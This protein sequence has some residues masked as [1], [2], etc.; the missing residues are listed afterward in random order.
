MREHHE[1]LIDSSPEATMEATLR[2]PVAPDW[3]VRLLFLLR[4][5][6]AGQ[7]SILEFGSTDGF[8]LLEQTPT[9]L[10]FGAAGRWQGG[11]R[12][13][14]NCDEWLGWS[15]PGIKIVADFRALPTG[16]GRTRLTTETRVWPLDRASAFV[17]R[18]YWLVVGPFSALIRRRWLRAIARSAVAG[19]ARAPTG[20][21]DVQAFGQV[22]TRGNLA[23]LFVEGTI[24]TSDDRPV[25]IDLSL[26]KIANLPDPGPGQKAVSASARGTVILD[27][28][29][30]TG[31]QPSTSGEI[32]RSTN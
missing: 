31:G 12:S 29:D 10:V 6:G 4:G 7:Q 28:V 2:L 16:H 20:L 14:T 26:R 1:R 3:I 22:E 13:A 24:S 15:A 21:Q 8:V 9:S 18:L 19:G 30:L 25:D 11:Q 23:R 17:F 32:T 27:G 5:L